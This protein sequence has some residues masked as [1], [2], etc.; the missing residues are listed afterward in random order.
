MFDVIF[1][2]QTNLRKK[3]RIGEKAEVK[4][5]RKNNPG[6]YSGTLIEQKELMIKDDKAIIIEYLRSHQGVMSITEN[7]DPAAIMRVLN[8]SK[9]AFKNALGGLYKEK[10]I[11]IL[12]DKIVL[13]E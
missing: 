8:M 9:S 7:S 6:D 11:E 12:E 1:V 10:K 13:M 5:V 4:I 3:Y 2:H